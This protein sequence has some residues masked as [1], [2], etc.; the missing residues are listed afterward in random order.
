MNSED[1][2]LIE[3]IKITGGFRVME[4]L[5]KEKMWKLDSVREIQKDGLVAEQT[6]AR[7]LSYEVLSSFLNEIGLFSPNKETRRTYE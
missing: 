6:L 7:Q 2:K 4:K 1:L 5:I 3:E